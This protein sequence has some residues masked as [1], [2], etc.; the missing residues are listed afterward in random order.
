MGIFTKNWNKPGPGVPKNAPKKRGIA[1]YFELLTREFGGLVKLNLLLFVIMLPASVLY[2]SFLLTFLAGNATWGLVLGL[3]A[4]I[5]CLPLGP[6][7]TAF[8]WLL[9]QMLRDDPGF[10][11][12]DFKRKFKENF[13]HM[14]L[15]GLVLGATV[16]S[17]GV[18]LLYTMLGAMKV[19]LPIM[20]LYFLATLL[21]ALLYPYFFTQAAYVDLPPLRLLQNS[22]LLG[23]A[24]LPRSFAGTLL[25]TGLLLFQIYFFPYALP[26]SL[27][28]GLSLPALGNLMWIWPHLDKTFNIDATLQKRHE[29]QFS[30]TN[31][32]DFE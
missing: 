9:A 8:Y 30:D 31:Q 16:G 15:P 10:L 6:A 18:M 25:G 12:H 22:F 5:A 2:L 20:A 3:L 11:W 26:V 13:R 17:F 24:K 21:T 1:R 7:L 14:A 29:E 28:I 32:V 27:L 23:F 4:L 19:S